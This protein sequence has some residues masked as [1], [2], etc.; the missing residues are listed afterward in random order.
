[1]EKVLALGLSLLM[2]LGVTGCTSNRPASVNSG[3]PASEDPSAAPASQDAAPTSKEP[4]APPVT[5]TVLFEGSNVSD[6]TAVVEAINARLAE[7][8]SGIVFRPIWG[9]WGDFD[10][11]ATT[12]LD[13]GDSSIDVFFTCSWTSNNY[14]KYAKNGLYARLDDPENNLLEQYGA[15]MK[16]AVPDLLWNGFI[17]DGGSGAGIYGVPGYKDYAQLYAWDVNNTRLGELGVNY[18]SIPW[19]QGGQVFYTQQFADAMETAKKKYGDSFYPLLIEA[20]VLP[21]MIAGTDSDPTQLLYFGYDPTDPRKPEKPVVTSRYDNPEYEKY[22]NKA[23]EYYQ[24]GYVD[25]AMSNAQQ[26]N[27]ARNAA[28]T[29]GNYLFNSQTYAYGYDQTASAE[30]GIDA[31]FPPIGKA[32]VSTGS[33][34]GAGYAVSV[35]SKNQDAAVKFLNLWYTDSQLA[36][37]LAYGLEGTHYTK[38]SDSTVTFDADARQSYLP[39]RN[40]MGNIFI[41]PPEDSAGSNYWNEFK[42]YNEEGV[43]VALLGFTFDTDPV[44]NQ[45]AALLTV[46]DQY[47][48]S[49][50]TGAVDPATVLPEFKNKLKA[51]GIDDVVAECNRQIDAF[52]AQ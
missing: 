1:M 2:I 16:A 47:V 40:G 15:G 44:K 4:V 31:K 45:V 20:E 35:Y 46:R 8:N 39:W 25:P 29:A 50:H 33:V 38:N 34:Q 41:L 36:T 32:I 49:L 14:V 5:V 22:L 13:T 17:V 21:R 52:F 43:G 3:A 7:L 26:A 9:T 18:D 51:N 6:D 48:A 37:L 12:A 42:A 10:S 23:R 19:A 30:R 28:M 27:D 24:A 11:K